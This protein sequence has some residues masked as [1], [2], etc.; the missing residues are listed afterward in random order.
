MTLEEIKADTAL[1]EQVLDHL[2]KAKQAWDAQRLSSLRKMT[3]VM[4]YDV[5]STWNLDLPIKYPNDNEPVKEMFVS[6][7]KPDGMRIWIQ[8]SD[9]PSHVYAIQPHD[10]VWVFVERAA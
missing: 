2:E 5:K 10:T 7:D 9:E 1:A 6:H 3:G 8:L 4:L